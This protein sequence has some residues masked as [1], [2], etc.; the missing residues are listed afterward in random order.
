MKRIIVKEEWCLGCRLCEYYCTFAC[1]GEE[2]IVKALKDKKIDANVTVEGMREKAEGK[3]SITF[4]VSCRHCKNPLC[5]TGCISGAL[6]KDPEG[7]V[8]ID[9][10]LCVACGS[11]VMLC[12]YGA[13]RITDD[14]AA[15]KCELCMGNSCGKPLC[16]AKCPN[17]AIVLE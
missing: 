14:G 6:S 3:S 5:I 11:C 17:A 7:A 8:R 10:N 9:K 2:D 1:S 4:A 13:I 16:V 12:P 15:S